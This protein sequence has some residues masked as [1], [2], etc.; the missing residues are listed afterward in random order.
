MEQPR[1]PLFCGT[2]L[3]AQIE[4]AEA[5]LILGAAESR[6]AREPDRMFVRSIAGGVAACAPEASPLNK[7]AGLGFADGPTDDEL[8]AI[9]AA[10]AA[11]GAPVQIELS[12]LGRA[13]LAE[14]LTVRGY[15]LVNFEDVLGLRLPADPAPAA[16]DIAIE[17]PSP[18]DRAAWL[19]VLID[20]FAHP[21]TEGVASHETYPRANLETIMSDLFRAPGY[22]LYLAR[23]EGRLAGAASLRVA[24]PIAQLTGSATLPAERRRGVQTALLARRLADAAAAGCAVA[25]IVTQPGSRSQR[26][27]RAR[28]FDLLYTRAILV[29]P[30]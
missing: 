16:A 2:E 9:E 24:G 13:G 8:A 10:A 11:R 19:D 23:R 5:E 18:A 30:I 12:S 26:N 6:R 15:R 21:D 22:Q 3:A 7:V 14:R 29:R 1:R 4:R 25:V 20:G 28:G 27:A 17:T